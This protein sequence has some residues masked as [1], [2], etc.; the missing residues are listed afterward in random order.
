MKVTAQMHAYL[1][2]HSK[3]TPQDLQTEKGVKALAFFADNSKYW[4][5]AGYT[6]IGQATVTVEVPDMRDLVNNKVA[7]LRE[8]AVAIRAEA[9][10][11]C[12]EIEGQ[13]QNLLAIEYA[14]SAP[15]Q[16]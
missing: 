2:S 8:Q 6:Y 15:E 14:P 5:E 16:E 12:T 1:P 13:I 10:A 4:A 3:A 9:T 7:S 11:K